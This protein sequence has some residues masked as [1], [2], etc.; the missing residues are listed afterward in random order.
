MPRNRGAAFFDVDGTLTTRTT[1]F[2][3][4]RHDLAARGFPARTFEEHRAQFREL[5]S[6]GVPRTVTSRRYFRLFAGRGAAELYRSGRQWFRAEWADGGLFRPEAVAALRR[7]ARAGDRVV[8]VSGSFAVCLD[9]L[10]ELLGADTVLC[11]GLEIRGG[12]FT[13]EVARPMLDRHK[14]RAVRE[15]ARDHRIDLA[16]SH[17]YGDHS[18]DLPL[19][20]QVGHPV[21]VGTDPAL[22]AAATA[23]CWARLAPTAP[24]EPDLRRSGE[25]R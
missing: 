22:A 23:G 1:L 12:R 8:L 4:L 16:A 14:A 6:V 19:L 25:E 10:A 7:H 21:A 13:G 2:R 15:F 24:P 3:F 20:R 17:A 18:S 5:T 9:P 11:T